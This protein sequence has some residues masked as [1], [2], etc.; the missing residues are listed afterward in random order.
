MR[1]RDR[2]TKCQSGLPLPSSIIRLTPTGS[3][4]NGSAS[5]DS[6]QK[7]DA[8]CVPVAKN[9]RIVLVRSV[10]EQPRT[11]NTKGRK[12]SFAYDQGQQWVETPRSGMLKLYCRVYWF[13]LRQRIPSGYHRGSRTAPPPSSSRAATRCLR[14]YVQCIHRDEPYF[15]TNQS[16]CNL[17]RTIMPPSFFCC[18]VT[19]C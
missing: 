4:K 10:V 19:V 17:F 16:S 18:R 7:A 1:C 11:A 9:V 6:C 12:L 3:F 14:F 2:H 5:C 8:Q 15:L 13:A